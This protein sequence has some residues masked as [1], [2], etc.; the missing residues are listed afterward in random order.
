VQ[1]QCEKL[2]LFLR[3]NEKN[4]FT[5]QDMKHAVQL[6]SSSNQNQGKSS[7]GDPNISNTYYKKNLTY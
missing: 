5:N 1:Q 6:V 3:I 2:G 7:D 4:H